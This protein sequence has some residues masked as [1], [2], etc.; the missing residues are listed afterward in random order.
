MKAKEICSNKPIVLSCLLVIVLFCTASGFAQVR[1]PSV[2]SDNMVIQ[3]GVKAPIW[4]W[5]EPGEKVKVGASWANRSWSATADVEGNWMVKIDSPKRAGGPY[6]MT[7]SGDGA[8]IEIGN[9]MAGEVWVCSGQSNM[10]WSLARTADPNQEIAAADYPN[11]RLF[12]VELHASGRPLDDCVAS[13][14][15]CN[16]ETAAK[17]SAVGYFFGR[18]LHKELNV[19]IGLIRTAWGGTRVEPWTPPVGFASV[20]G[21]EDIGKQLADAETEYSKAVA[22]SLDA[23]EAWVGDSRKALATNQAVPLAPAWPGHPLSSN[24][25]PTGLYNAMV[26][27]LVPF[28]IRGA[29]WYQGESNRADGLGYQAK[30]KAL[31]NGWRTVWGQGDFPFYFVQLAPYRYGGDPGLLPQIWQAQMQTLSVPNT[32]MAVINDIGN[33]ADIHPK[34]KQDV[35]KRLA[36]WAMAKT[37]RHSK[38]VHSG[39][40]YRSMAVDDNKIRIRF[41]HAGGGLASR[42]G[43]DL[44]WF[45]IAGA[46]KNFV[47]AKAKLE[48][49]TVVVWS[50]AVAKPVAVRFAWHQEAEPN[51]MNKE[52][53]PASSFRTDDWPIIVAEPK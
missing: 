51:L 25:R 12:A 47:E 45:R 34:N 19:P 43:N 39:P 1:L 30:M 13:W 8:S 11:I 22:E 26:Y 21:L 9:I 10:Q 49:Y 16:P 50:D 32:G 44:T 24:R 15:A 20:A 2:I 17:F 23:V 28:A 48:G 31:I 37:Y 53:L 29:I 27:P 5:A 18:H 46:D 6:Q 14:S 52:G 40:L 35:G 41:D 33:L 7:I 4:G 3:R 42:D 36:L 38:L